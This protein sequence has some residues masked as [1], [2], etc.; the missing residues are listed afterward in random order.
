MVP[1]WRQPLLR[2]TIQDIFG[3]QPVA[4]SWEPCTILIPHE[5]QEYVVLPWTTHYASHWHWW[6]LWCRPLSRYC[7]HNNDWKL[8]WPVS[9]IKHPHPIWQL[10]ESDTT[11][12]RATTQWQIPLLCP[13]SS[14]VQL[15][16]VLFLRRPLCF[17]NPISVPAISHQLGM[18][19]VQIRGAHSFKNSPRAIKYST[20]QRTCSIISAHL[21]IHQWYM[22]ISFSLHAF[23]QVTQPQSSGNSRLQ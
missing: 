23:R 4:L 10:R 14:A 15:G 19:L 21:A 17:S 9:P 12:C 18:W 3:P 1:P 22:G 8:P 7:L 6:H 2:P 11:K 16:C 13:A 20:V 5:A